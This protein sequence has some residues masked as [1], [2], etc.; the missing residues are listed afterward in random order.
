[1]LAD[2]EVVP[3]FIQQQAKPAAIART[4]GPLVED[5]HAR[6][7]MI[8]AFDAIISKLGGGGASEHA[9]QAILEELKEGQ[10]QGLPGGLPSS[11]D[12]GGPGETA[13]L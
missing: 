4:M 1:L 2:K 7:Q 12:H 8:S 5:G 10:S 3:E 11:K 13:A 9:A 6:E